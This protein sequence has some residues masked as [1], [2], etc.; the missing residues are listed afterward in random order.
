MQHLLNAFYYIHTNYIIHR[1]IK[2][3]NILIARN[4]VLKLTDF[5]LSKMIILPKLDWKNRHTYLVVTIWYH[6]PPELRLGER[7]NG[8]AIDMWGV[9]CIFAKM[10]IRWPIMHGEIEQHQLQLI[11]S[12]CSSIELSLWPSVDSLLLYNK[13][14]LLGG[15]YRKLYDHMK[16]YIKEPSALHLIDQ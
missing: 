14:N 4:G 3:A 8:P 9:G 16:N 12:L 15:E 10:R 5:G 11:S 2:P 6:R 13:M 7:N 1:D